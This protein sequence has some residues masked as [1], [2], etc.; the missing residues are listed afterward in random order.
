MIVPCDRLLVSDMLGVSEPIEIVVFVFVTVFDAESIS[1]PVALCVRG[2]DND[3]EALNGLV[4]VGVTLDSEVAVSEAESAVGVR[5]R[6]LD[7]VSVSETDLDSVLL[8]EKV[9]VELGV[10]MDLV[11]ESDAFSV[12][13]SDEVTEISLVRLVR[14]WV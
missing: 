2:C 10:P 8:N 7:C 1:E 14:V 9:F 13:V 5:V 3:F 4:G 12:P 6:V 11:L